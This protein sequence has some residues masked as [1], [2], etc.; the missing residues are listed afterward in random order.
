[1]YAGFATK[2]QAEAMVHHISDEE[3]FASPYGVT[4]LAKDE[5]MFDLS[6]T[7]NPSNWLGPIWLVAN[8]IIFKGLLN[9]G[10]IEEAEK[11]VKE[12]YF[13]WEKIWKQQ[14]V[15]MNTMIHLMDIR[16]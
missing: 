8:H 14:A 3:T 9:Y 6:V 16:S 5:K 7:N 11:Y 2:E 12:H 1:M 13:F 10:Y 4:T 15:F